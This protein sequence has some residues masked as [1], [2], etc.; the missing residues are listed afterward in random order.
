MSKLRAF[1]GAIALMSATALAAPAVAGPKEDLEQVTRSIASTKSMTANF[2]Q[3]DGKGRSMKGALSLQRPGKIRFDY[4]KGSDMLLVSDGK[5]LSF[6]DYSVGQ[7]SDWPVA[8]SPLAILL[9]PN[10][11]LRRIARVISNEKGVLTVR[12][13]DARH[14]EFGTLILAFN[15]N[16]AA[17]GGLELG[18]WVA[19][20]AQNK[21]TKVTLSGQRYN[22]GIPASRFTFE[23]PK[24]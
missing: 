18:G 2:V 17:P 10:P 11:D 1:A 21:K 22:V 24:K 12:A 13:R 4:G 9:S 7:V 20:D 19:I 8:K 3:T 23:K 14:P 5:T 6:V 16:G 15:K